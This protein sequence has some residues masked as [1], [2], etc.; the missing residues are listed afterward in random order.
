MGK[1]RGQVIFISTKDA[2]YGFRL[3]GLSHYDASEENIEEIILKVIEQTDAGLVIVEE[4][5]I[6]AMPD[7]RLNAIEQSWHG[8]LLALP[9]PERPGVEFEDYVSRL[10]RR[11]IG[12]H[13]RVK[14]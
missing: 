2:E 4:P 9:S 10:I 13:M 1:H 11:A 7:D 6:R 5:L 3:A 12:Y 8:I 14:V